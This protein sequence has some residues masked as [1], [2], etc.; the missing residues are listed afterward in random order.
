[1]NFVPEL[2]VRRRHEPALPKARLLMKVTPFD[3]SSTMKPLPSVFCWNSV[4][5]KEM[6]PSTQL[7]VPW[8]SNSV[9]PLDHD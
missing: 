1:M 5:S 7:L 9:T 3:S 4:F 6:L 2:R 8:A